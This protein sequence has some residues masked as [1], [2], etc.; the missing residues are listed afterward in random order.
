L[1]AKLKSCST[2]IISWEDAANDT[3][4]WKQLRGNGGNKPQQIMVPS[5]E[6][7]V[8]AADLVTPRLVFIPT[9]GPIPADVMSAYSSVGL[10][11]ESFIRS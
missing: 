8:F 5:L 11:G 9:W 1:K 4:R 10:T 7:S 6:I 2:S 3:N